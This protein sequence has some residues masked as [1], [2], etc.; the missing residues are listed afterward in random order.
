[1]A[2]EQRYRTSIGDLE[3]S[4]RVALA[5]QREEQPASPPRDVLD[6]E[7]ADRLSLLNSPAGAGRLRHR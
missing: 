2:D 3:A 4:A 1:M 5:D 7:D 6:P